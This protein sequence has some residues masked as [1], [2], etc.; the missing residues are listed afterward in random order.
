VIG[1]VFGLTLNGTL[2]AYRTDPSLLGIPYDAAVTR[3][4]TSDQKMRH[5]L[6]R[7]PGVEAFYAQ[8]LAEVETPAGQS[9]NVR[10]VEGDLAA[11]PFRIDEGRLLRPDTQEAIA[12]RGLLDWLGL[13]VGDEI[14]VAFKDL[15]NRPITWQIVG[16]YPEP[17]NAGQMLMVNLSTVTRVLKQA[18]PNTYFLKLAPDYDPA[19]L[20]H[21][22][23][24]R[25]DSDLDI[26]FVAQAI[27]DEVI[28]VQLAIF[29][30]S[31]ILIGIALINVFNTSLLAMQEKVRVVGI[32]KTVGMT[33]AQVMTMTNTAA[34]FLGLFAAVLG[35]PIG[36]MFT[37]ALLDILSTSYGFSDV[38]ATLGLL[39]VLSLVPLMV[40]V[41]V[42]GSTI[43]G[44]WAAK[45]PIVQVL[46]SE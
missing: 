8:Y 32:L 44:R 36:L 1:I 16:Q 7:A 41:S 46:R 23:K 12:G 2:D 22:L 31:A 3:E 34:G 27:P 18:E 28:Y 37:Q 33:P 30:L 15:E 35:I 40:L 39:Y 20:K 24:P 4:S 9:F 42:A 11:F 29:A 17:S 14:T 13:E 45:L 38:H 10:A 6:S 5:L 43:P 19:Q 26:T 25:Q 21:Y